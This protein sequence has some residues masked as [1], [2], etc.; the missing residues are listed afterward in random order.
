MVQPTCRS[1]AEAP[2]AKILIRPFAVILIIL[3]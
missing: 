1:E 3:D 2:R